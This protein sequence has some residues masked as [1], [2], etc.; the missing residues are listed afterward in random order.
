MKTG[1]L[2]LNYNG[3]KLLAECLPS[4]IE[5]A[6]VSRYDTDVVV[7]D[8][9]STDHS[10]E[11]IE[12]FMPRLTLIK[13][14]NRVL[15]SFNDV[16]KE[17]DKDVLILLN[18][19]MKVDTGFVDPLVES[20]E[21]DR[22]I[23]LAVPKCCTFKGDKVECGRTKAFIRYG[24]FGALGRFKGWEDELDRTALTFQSGFGAVARD[25]FLELGGYD[26]IYLPGRLEDS[27]ICFRAWKNG[28][29][30]VYEPRSVIYHKGGESFNREF[31]RKG[32]SFIDTRNSLLFFWKNITRPLYWMEHILFFPLRLIYLMLKG[33]FSAVR[34]VFG[35]VG[36]I[37]DV[38]VRRARHGVNNVV[39][40][41]EIFRLFR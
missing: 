15:C 27:D 9:E 1:I 3:E 29:K 18:N 36:M 32:M 37:R 25:K 6:S 31:G 10:I 40:D 19:D 33:D 26:D 16:I 2:I 11:V 39:S 20:L 4:I 41:K 30:N 24:W 8:N 7:V 34:G 38:R 28:W 5:A 35:A 22:D 14:A 13:K 17:L 23:F 12:S 21:K